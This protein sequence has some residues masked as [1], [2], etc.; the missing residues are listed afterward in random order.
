MKK[1]YALL[2]FIIPL[3]GYAQNTHLVTFKVNTANITVGPNGLFLG[4]GI[5]GGANEV[6]LLD[7]DGNGIYEGTDSL[8]GTGGGNFIFLNSPSNNSDWGTKEVLSGLPCSDPANYNDRILPSFTQDTTLLFC[9]GTCA[10]DTICPAPPIQRSIHFKVDMNSPFAPTSFSQPY[11]SGSFN[12]WS[13]NSWAMTDNDSDNV[14]EY[15]AMLDENVV[16]EYKFSLD[17]WAGQ[18]QFSSSTSDSICTQNFGGYVNRVYTVGSSDDTIMY[19]YNS[20]NVNCGLVTPP[21]TPY[22]V[23]FKVSAANINVGPNGLY[24]GGGVIGGATEVLLTDP[25][26]NGV[27]EGTDTLSGAGGGNFIFLNSPANSSDWDTKE[28]LQGLPCS[29]PN[30]WDDRILPSFTQDTTLLFC[31]GT[32]ATDTICPAPWIST[33]PLSGVYTI[34]ANS[35]GARNYTSF[36]SAVADLDSLGVSGA[37]TFNVA[38]GIYD[39]Q[40]NLGQVTGAS[41]INT[42][43]FFG[44]VGNAFSPTVLTYT[45]VGSTDNWTVK[46]TGTDYVTFD[47]VTITSGGSSYARLIVY[48]DTVTDFNL[49]NCHLIGKTS[50]GGSISTFYAGLYYTSPAYANGNWHISDNTFDSVSYAIYVYGSGYGANQGADSVFIEDN[51]INANYNGFYVRYAKYQKMHD[52]VI[53]DINGGSLRNYAYYPVYELDVQNNQ[54]NDAAYGIYMYTAPPTSGATGDIKVNVSNNHFEGTSYG[55]RVGGSSSS[56]TEK[57]KDLTIENNTIEAGGTSFN[58]GIYLGY[59]NAPATARAK[60]QNNMIA[61]NTTSTTGTLY[62]IYP[63]HCANVDMF[64]NS[65]AANGGSLTN[66]RLIY[67]NHSTSTSLFTPGGNSLKN[68]IVANFNGGK[69]VVGQTA[70][71]GSAAYCETGTNLF[72]TTNATP[73]TNFTPDST[74]LTGDPVFEDPFTDLHVQGPDAD[75]AGATLGVLTDIDGDTRSTTTPD[76]GADEYTFVPICY[77]PT[78]VTTTN[79][80]ASSFD[81]SWSSANTVIGYQARA[82]AAG[83]T[84]YIYSSGTT[85]PASF[86]GLSASTTY[87]VEVREI[88]AVGDTSGWSSAGTVTTLCSPILVTEATPFVENFDGPNWSPNTAGYDSGTWDNCWTPEPPLTSGT[89]TWQVQ[90]GGT[91]SSNTGP[92]AANSGLNYIYHEASFG[93]NGDSTIVKTPSFNLSLNNP[94]LSFAYHMFGALQDAIYIDISTNSG[95]SFVTIDTV[96]ATMANQSDPWALHFTDLSN[97]ANTTVILAFRVMKGTSWTKDAAIDDFSIAKKITCFPASNL[98]SSNESN[99]SFEASWTT[100]NTSAIGYQVRYALNDGNANWSYTSGVGSSTLIT[101]LTP[102]TEYEWNVREI[103][104][105]GDTGAW[106]QPTI[107]RTKLCPSA[108]ECSVKAVLYDSYGDGWNGGEIALEQKNALGQWIP[109]AFLGTNFNG[110]AGS[111][112]GDSLIEYANVC[113]GDSFRVIGTQPGSYSQEMGWLLTNSEGDTIDYRQGLNSGPTWSIGT[114]FGSGLADCNLDKC[115]IVQATPRPDVPVARICGPQNVVLS[116]QTMNPNFKTLWMDYESYSSPWSVVHTGPSYDLGVVDRFRGF[117][118][119]YYTNNDSVPG[120]QVGP[121]SSLFGGYSNTSNGT[122]FSVQ[123]PISIDSITVRSNG[124]KDFKLNIFEAQGNISSGNQGNIMQQSNLI[125]LN[126]AGTHKVYVGIVLMPGN[127]FMNVDFL[128]GGTGMLHRAV[129]GASYPYA[130]S[131]VIS[132]DSVDYVNQSYAPYVYDWVVKEICMGPFKSTQVRVSSAVDTM[133]SVSGPLDF[134]AGEAVTLTAAS[135][136][137]PVVS[138]DTTFTVLEP[139]HHSGEY[140]NTIAANIVSTPSWGISS[141]ASVSDTLVLMNDGSSGMNTDY[142]YSFPQSLCGCDST[143]VV[144]NP[145]IQGKVVLISRGTCDFGWKAYLA[146]LAGASGVVIYNAYPDAATGGGTFGML[147]GYYGTLVTIPATFVANSTGII[148]KNEIEEAKIGYSYL[149]STGDTTQSITVNQAGDYYATLTTPYGHCSETT[150]TYSTSIL[151]DPNVTVVADGPLAFCSEDTLNLSGVTSTAD[152]LVGPIPGGNGSAG[153]MFNVVNTSG[154]P[155]SITGFAQGPGSGNSSQSNVT[156][157]VYYSPGDYTTQPTSSW[158]AAGSAVTNLT[159]SAST[160][161]VPVAVTIPAGATY[162]FYVGV[163]SGAVQYTNGTGTPGVSTWFSN[164]DMTVTEG[165]GGAYP[166]PA[167]SPRCWNGTIYYSSNSSASG[168]SYLWSNGDTTQTTSITQAGSYYAVVTSSDGCVDTTDTF[169]ASVFAAPDTT[170]SSSGSL[171]FCSDEDVTLTAASGQSYLWSTGDTTQSITVHQAG[172]YSAMITTSDGCSEMTA[173]YTT[174]VFADADTSVSVSGSLDFCSY[175]D[176]TLTAA[177]G[178]SYLWS[179]GATTQSI[180]VNQA[181]SY[182]AVV[183]TSNGCSDTTDTYT[184]SVFADPDINITTSG[185]LDFCSYEDVVLTAASGQTY[186]WSTGETTQSITVDQ[187]GSYHAIITTSDGCVDTTSNFTTTIFADADISV[188]TSGSL[189]FC[190]YDDVTIT[191]AAGQSYVWSTGDTSQSITTNQVGSYSFTATT[192]NG[193]ID[194]SAV[195]TTSVFADPDTSVVVTQTLF[196]ASDSAV[197]I[198]A[199]G[200]S[201]LWS[202]GDI[203]QATIVNTTGSYYVTATTNDG[204]EGNSDTISITVVPDIVVPQIVVNGL[205][206][207]ATGSSTTFTIILDSTQTYQWNIDG[208]TIIS[209]QGTDSLVVNWG[210]P[211]TNVTVWLV[212]SNGV[213]SDSTSVSFAISGIGFEEDLMSGAKLYP[214]PNGGQFTVF[215]PEEYIGS[216]MVVIDG[217]GRVIERLMVQDSRTNIDVRDKPKGVY[218]VQIKSTLGIKTLPV[219]IQ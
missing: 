120:H 5:I 147:P 155:L 67:L 166:S 200:Q 25:D 72:Y 90:S 197:L 132:L 201:Y 218:R 119:R 109:V 1:I 125:S 193:C 58:Y 66:S 198:A 195:Y 50:S 165:L 164:N 186:S 83:T 4:G 175:D 59:V 95:V 89:Y 136:M 85:G 94:E 8:S 51:T 3:M 174:T 77:L 44:D 152:S 142:G 158:V 194:T 160:G 22:V 213:C 111:P 157:Q 188:T 76:I 9:F 171:D 139:S 122:W 100:G 14:W 12:G 203:T 141:G 103:C 179:N 39:E 23:T 211:D 78:G 154:A 151:S 102:G 180:T 32:C 105:V 79:V 208:G 54:V 204:C 138:I 173:T 42:I 38:S 219:V 7:P 210:I 196:C 159:A 128:H 214:N 10:T 97:Y 150:S 178:Q 101:G 60:V 55:I 86:T 107:S 62:G 63:Y 27:Y 153:N 140:P 168:Q 114:V 205:G 116:D 35:F 21:P 88:C 17:N 19:C 73:H 124:A 46:M 161:Y 36:A 108:F 34:N 167:F 112:P 115:L 215:V 82:W 170:V 53:N 113:V 176:V 98:N 75:N 191:A 93:G 121:S 199:P 206:W 130:V 135:R 71:T 2:M 29:D 209:G 183:T 52:N 145:E 87:S 184:T 28:I 40:V 106:A 81:A 84:T 70:T 56:T 126:S 13:G 92:L 129:T 68:N 143:G 146:Q 91:P 11:L 104:A 123:S 177:P 217:V 149:W 6:Q 33:A 189:D 64:H 41:S 148:L 47:N 49:T 212:I 187:A 162:G 26:G 61:L 18:E 30:N 216:E 24:L 127:Y 37:V 15:T 31:F 185:S 202:N 65:I 16:Y 117:L 48:T 45:P 182:Y 74:D 131:N 144:S 172:S 20:C 43:T 207:V 134:C 192:L 69:C 99:T 57:I 163:T 190:S 80:T 96:T 156:V 169:A 110:A 181:G 118:V 137:S 133:L